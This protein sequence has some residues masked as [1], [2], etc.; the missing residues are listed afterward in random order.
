M[1]VIDN[2]NS[3]RLDVM[4]NDGT[5][6]SDLGFVTAN[7]VID[8]DISVVDASNIY[9][10]YI[11]NE[12]DG[13]AYIY[14]KKYSAGTWPD[15]DG[16]YILKGAGTITS[17]GHHISIK[18]IS[19]SEIYL[20]YEYPGYGTIACMKWNGTSWNNLGNPGG[21]GFGAYPSMA[22]ISGI[23]YISYEDSTISNMMKIVKY[24]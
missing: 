13:Y 3:D 5:G 18:A 20:A 23:P 11:R 7:A 12:V 24:Q 15:V 19:A 21:F 4:E 9:A 8:M 14:V 16:S 10:A 17:P 22:V 1:A 2:N 6:W